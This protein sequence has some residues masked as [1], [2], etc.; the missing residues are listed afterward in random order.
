MF[1]IT[2]LPVLA[3]GS[4]RGFEA[5]MIVELNEVRTL[6]VQVNRHLNSEL[7][8]SDLVGF[9]ESKSIQSQMSLTVNV[10]YNESM[11]MVTCRLK[12]HGDDAIGLYLISSD[13]MLIGEI[14]NEMMLFAKQRD[15]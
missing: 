13:Q 8:V 14:R 3:D 6:L 11:H 2:I 7:N 9:A 1:L 5:S 12:K 15:L 10:P 4:S